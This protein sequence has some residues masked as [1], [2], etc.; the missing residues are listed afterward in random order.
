MKYLVLLLCLVGCV[1]NETATTEVTVYQ[2]V[3]ITV[4]DT[5]PGTVLIWDMEDARE[6]MRQLDGAVAGH[7]HTVGNCYDRH[8]MGIFAD[9][10]TPE[11]I[12][13]CDKWRRAAL[14]RIRE[15]YIG[16]LQI[17]GVR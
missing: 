3:D 15:R 9:Y 13:E 14:L 11:A 5:I 16:D 8:R 10:Y 6:V 2:F 12:A 17:L 4:G 1:G 7:R